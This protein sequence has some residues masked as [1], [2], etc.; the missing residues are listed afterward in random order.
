MLRLTAAPQRDHEPTISLYDTYVAVTTF[1]VVATNFLVA[2]PIFPVSFATSA[3]QATVL[4]TRVRMT[5]TH[6]AV[7]SFGESLNGDLLVLWARITKRT[8]P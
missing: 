8:L 7:S 2:V 6:T 4:G 3:G 5:G 1:I